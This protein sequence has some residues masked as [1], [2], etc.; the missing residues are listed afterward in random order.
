MNY[1]RNIINNV[2]HLGLSMPKQ[3]IKYVGSE[4]KKLS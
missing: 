2:E 1:Q 3:V 4:I